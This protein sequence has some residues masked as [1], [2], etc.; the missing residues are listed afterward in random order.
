[1][2]RVVCGC[3][4]VFKAEDRHSGKRTRCPA[5]GT[6]LIIGQTPASGSGEGELE[7]VPSWWYPS[8]PPVP[9]ATDPPH[10]GGNRDP[11]AIRT[12]VLESGLV[13]DGGRTDGS[14]SGSGPGTR[15]VPEAPA[16]AAPTPWTLAGAIAAT[17][18]LTLGVLGWIW[19]AVPVTNGTTA[20]QAPRT[21]TAPQDAGRG[22]NSGLFADRSGSTTL[23]DGF[24]GTERERPARP[25]RR[26]RL[27]VPAYIYPNQEGRLQW[28]RIIDA[29][30]KVDLVAVVNPESGPGVERGAR[31]GLHDQGSGC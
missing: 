8:D 29:A 14:A 12:A 16:D 7:E 18:A 26:L 10:L 3:G 28:R 27:L 15:T 13:L 17:A 31:H 9:A 23:E 4:R 5:C 25:P 6:N 21:R 24:R 30:A 19:W 20:T 1:M 11:E 2:I 22:P